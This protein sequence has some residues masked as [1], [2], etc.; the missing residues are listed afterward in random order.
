MGDSS[1]PDNLD[2]WPADP[3]KLLGVH[4]ASSR[5][6]VKRAYARLI[7]VYKPEHFPEHFRRLRDAYELL[8]QRLA[9]MESAG[10]VEE[11]NVPVPEEHASPN[12]FDVPEPE[13]PAEVPETPLKFASPERDGLW[14]KARQGDLSM[15]YKHYSKLA[16]SGRAGEELFLRLFWML[17]LSPELDS[18]RDARDWL[19]AGLKQ[20]GLRGRL[21]ELYRCELVDDPGEALSPRCDAALQSSGHAG[22]LTEL[23]I[24][25]WGAA[26][27]L[28]K[29]ECIGEDLDALRGRLQDD[30]AVWG[31]LLLAA[32]DQLA[33]APRG[34]CEETYLDCLQEVEQVAEHSM[35]IATE[36]NDR[37]NLRELV[38]SC[39]Q[40]KGLT[41]L[42]L[43]WRKSLRSL[44]MLSWN[45]P[46]GGFRHSLLEVLAPLV[47]NP[48]VG[49]EWLDRLQARCAPA[50]HRLGALIVMLAGESGVGRETPSNDYLRVRLIE[51]LIAI[52]K[53][54]YPERWKR[55]MRSARQCDRSGR[56]ELLMFC[57][58]E[59]VTMRQ[60]TD[61]LASGVR[62]DLAQFLTPAGSAP[63]H[64]ICL[65]YLAFW[66]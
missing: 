59:S 56:L 27:R 11:V 47:Q 29:W 42:P 31:R 50:M 16:G 45:Q 58:Q 46:L 20:F 9:W 3:Y 25:R 24:A 26:T 5:K 63:L 4:H 66:A 49:M 19:L 23:V 34:R 8:D 64:F 2:Q 40:L 13:E 62:Q 14:E 55:W 12:P 43:E 22:L 38:Q 32:I 44:L 53:K 52:S 33:W 37:D 48:I 57:L 51:F 18:A 10:I 17:R 1:L 35:P 28:M 65:A 21:A 36:L 6:D 39:E 54:N 41:N 61:L 30:S 60:M 15:A 7:R